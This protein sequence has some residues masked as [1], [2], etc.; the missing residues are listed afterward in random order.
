MFRIPK[1]NQITGSLQVTGLSRRDIGLR[2]SRKT[3]NSVG[4]GPA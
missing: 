1:V 3:V 4:Q 2:V